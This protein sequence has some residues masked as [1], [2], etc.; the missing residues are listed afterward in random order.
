MVQHR[1]T[2]TF[3]QI[4]I[5]LKTTKKK[6]KSKAGRQNAK[7]PRGKKVYL[8]IV[9]SCELY[10]NVS[11]SFIQAFVMN[12]LDRSW[13]HS[14]ESRRLLC[15][16]LGW[17]VEGIYI[18]NTCWKG[19]AGKGAASPAHFSGV[20]ESEQVC[21]SFPLGGERAAWLGRIVP[22]N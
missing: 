5:S 16:E 18:V 20:A 2:G 22:R 9:L 15:R 10:R 7:Q 1:T 3:P 17:G 6:Y 8:G 12:A 11:V 19:A 14:F 13:Q 4:Y 21:P